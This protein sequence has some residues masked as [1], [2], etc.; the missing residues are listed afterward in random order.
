MG[1]KQVQALAIAATSEKGFRRAGRFWG[2]GTQKVPVGEFTEAQLAA[3]RDE[4]GKGLVVVDT[5]ME[6][7][8]PDAAKAPAES[9]A[10]A[11]A[12]GAAPPAEDPAPAK[13]AKGSK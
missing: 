1:I 3:L 12:A 7:E 5:T 10:A 8:V 13:P 4:A 2:P 11:S 9:P 6:I